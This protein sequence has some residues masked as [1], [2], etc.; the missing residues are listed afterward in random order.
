MKPKQSSVRLPVKTA[1]KKPAPA[2]LEKIKQK[3]KK[4]LTEY[5]KLES[6]RL[7]GTEHEKRL[8]NFLQM[9]DAMLAILH[10]TVM[11]DPISTEELHKRVLTVVKNWIK[12]TPPFKISSLV[13][14]DK[15]IDTIEI[16]LNIYV[17]L[18]PDGEKVW[19]LRRFVKPDNLTG[20]GKKI[21]LERTELW[22][23]TGKLND[24]LPDY[25]YPGDA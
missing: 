17:E 1:S 2:M 8:F 12:S 18:L 14:S 16:S 7:G 6:Q 22:L 4:L 19:N 21:C 5:E 13:S 9:I 25:S 23:D 3:Q 24:R 15:V 10:S 20:D 11:H